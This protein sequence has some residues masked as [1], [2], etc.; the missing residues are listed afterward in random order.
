MRIRRQSL[1][2]LIALLAI[3]RP[4]PA[5]AHDLMP[6][7]LSIEAVSDTRYDVT[8][9]VPAIGATAL[10]LGVSFHAGCTGADA[11][12]LPSGNGAFLARYRLDCAAPLAGTTIGLTGLAETDADVLVRIVSTIGAVQTERALPERPEVVVAAAPTRLG[13]AQTYFALGAQHILLGLDHLLFVLALILLIERRSVLFWTITAFTLAHSVTLALSALGLADMPQPLVEAL[14]ALSIVFLAAE[15]VR[16]W[17][18]EGAAQPRFSPPAVA[19][20]FGLLHGLGFGGALMRIGLPAGEV[21]IA[22]LAF[23]LGVE[24]GQLL[25][26]AVAL[27]TT[28]SLVALLAIRLAPARLPLT[29][30]IGVVA[31]MWFAQR[32]A[33]MMFLA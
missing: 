16:M 12:F 28:A 3:V 11:P 7:L 1:F 2:I 17:R 25:V 32:V 9:K 23:N 18:T 27:L 13:L 29:Y 14:I 26:V 30:A 5:T 8:F 31:A 20:M 24:A 22:L 21:P 10:P 19:F 4:L 33:A 15:G 6:S